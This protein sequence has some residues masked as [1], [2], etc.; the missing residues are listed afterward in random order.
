MRD[1]QS[2]IACLEDGCRQGVY[3]GAVIEAGSSAGVAW[4]HAVGRLTYA[5]DAPCVTADTVYDLASLTKV[6]ATTVVTIRSVESRHLTLDD[7]VAEWIPAWRQQ[8]DR[9]DVR[10]RDLLY[11]SAGLPAW[12]PLYEHCQGQSAYVDAIAGVPLVF[13][14]RTS[15]L[16]SDL[17]FV[18]LGAILTTAIGADLATGAASSWSAIGPVAAS[19]LSYGIPPAW[20]PDV[21]PCR[22]H[23]KRGAISPGMVDDTNAWAYGAAAGHAGVFGRARG[24]GSVAAS[25]LRLLRGVDAVSWCARDTAR[26]FASRGPVPGSSRALGWDTMLPTSSCGTLMSSE[27]IGHTGFTGTSLWIDP[28]RDLYVVVLTNRVHPEARSS[29]GIQH[30]RRVVHDA[31]VRVWDGAAGSR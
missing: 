18:L 10:V 19:H 14:P 22:V 17:G 21:A 1:W 5:S 27:S 30:V 9:E 13:P 4:S 23:D 7:H 8:T 31:V 16:Y 11:H 3:P 25:W 12:L 15:S 26:L 29:D 20:Y 2:V 24:V 6:L 28:P